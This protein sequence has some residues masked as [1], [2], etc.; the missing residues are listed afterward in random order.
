MKLSRNL[1]K[2]RSCYDYRRQV[3]NKAPRTDVS[4][5]EERGFNTVEHL[6]RYLSTTHK[7]TA[8]LAKIGPELRECLAAHAAWKADSS[9][10]NPWF[11]PSPRSADK[12]VDKS[13]F[14]H[15]LARGCTKLGLPKR[16][17]H[18][19]RPYSVGVLQSK[20]VAVWIGHKTAGN[21]IVETYGEILPIKLD[22]MPTKTDL[23]WIH[24]DTPSAIAQP[25]FSR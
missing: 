19:Q 7:E 22:R 8:A 21:L 3:A 25:V 15:A 13:S 16:T 5:P 20:G 12:P 10:I 1:I 23:A 17:A 9:P 14:Q 2:H 6:W 11:F 18:K 24:T 4:R